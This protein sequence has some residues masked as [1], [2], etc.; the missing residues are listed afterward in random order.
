MSGNEYFS[1]FEKQSGILLKDLS[2]I[3]FSELNISTIL[4]KIEGIK[5]TT[6]MELFLKR[7]INSNDGFLLIRA[8]SLLA[9]YENQ[10][11]REMDCSSIYDYCKKR[12]KE[13]PFH[14]SNSVIHSD[15]KTAKALK[16][17]IGKNCLGTDSYRPEGFK[18]SDFSG[19]LN[20]LGL[21][22]KL[23]MKNT[24]EDI[25][26]DKFFTYTLYEYDTYINDLLKQKSKKLEPIN[27]DTTVDVTDSIIFPPDSLDPLAKTLDQN[28]K[29]IP[30]TSHE[31]KIDIFK[32]PCGTIKDKEIFSLFSVLDKRRNYRSKIFE[33]IA[34]S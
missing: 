12:T 17:I 19:H 10:W 30:S 7:C 31:T 23:I 22:Y 32:L 29:I 16:I 11:Y 4:N 14:L 33:Y 27:N 2:P 34:Q 15:I 24:S 1:D 25:D 28:E 3:D 20:K 9:I 18:V 5:N 13:S 26:W 21:L 6:A 8:L